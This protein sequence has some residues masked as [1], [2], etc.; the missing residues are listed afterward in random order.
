MI[1]EGYK[2]FFD[3]ICVE[4]FRNEVLEIETYM[5]NHLKND[6]ELN[7]DTILETY[8]KNQCWLFE[9]RFEKEV[10]VTKASNSISDKGF[11]KTVAK[12]QCL[13]TCRLRN[14]EHNE[15]ILKK[16]ESH[17]LF[18]PRL[19]QNFLDLIVI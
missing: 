11:A 5:K 15:C 4:W 12:D 18:I 17:S 14:L 19:F 1:K 16:Q 9:K 8:S 6:I 7:P 13:L 3:E 2:K 10:V